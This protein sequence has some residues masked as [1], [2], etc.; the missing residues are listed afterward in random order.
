[1]IHT[2]TVPY[3]LHRPQYTHLRELFDR[4]PDINWI[5]AN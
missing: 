5:L 4:Q 2:E 3:E 1:M